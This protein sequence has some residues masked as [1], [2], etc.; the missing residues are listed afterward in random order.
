VVV[1][2]ERQFLSF[3]ARRPVVDKT[4]VAVKDYRTDPLT[5]PNVARNV[6]AHLLGLAMGLSDN[7]DPTTPMCGRPAPCRPDLSPAIVPAGFH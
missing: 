4:A 2:S 5:L 3:T 7:A 6:I 1:P